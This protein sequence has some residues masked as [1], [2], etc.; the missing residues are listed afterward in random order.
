MIKIYSRQVPLLLRTSAHHA[1]GGKQGSNINFIRH[2]PKFLQGHA[3]LLGKPQDST[4]EQL[5]A[6]KAVPDT[7]DSEEDDEAERQVCECPL[8]NL[9]S[10][11]RLWAAQ[12][13]F[14]V[15]LQKLLAP[16]QLCVMHP[17]LSR[18]RGL[19]LVCG[20]SRMR[21]RGR[22]HKIPAW[23]SNIQNWR[24]MWRRT[25]LRR[26]RSSEIRHFQRRGVCCQ[27]CLSKS[28]VPRH[29]PAWSVLRCT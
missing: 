26:Q 11:C 5:T 28:S 12:Q 23:S 1:G 29:Q 15:I 16:G 3:H 21:C 9:E 18:L 10:G 14:S 20:S 25:K 4:E 24:A 13:H 8:W 19:D 7:W 27:A 17:I 6:K 2:V 22:W